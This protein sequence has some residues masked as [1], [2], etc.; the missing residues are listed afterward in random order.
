MNDYIDRALLSKPIYAEEDNATGFGM[1]EYEQD[2]YNEGI[3]VSWNRVLAAPNVDA[4]PVVRCKDCKHYR[5]VKGNERCG[6]FEYYFPEDNDFCSC[7]ERKRG[8]E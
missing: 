3:D 4:V 5:G 1:T 6:E 7:G 2:S 8:D